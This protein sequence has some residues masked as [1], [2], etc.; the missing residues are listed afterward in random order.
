[1]PAPRLHETIIAE[2]IVELIDQNLIGNWQDLLAVRDVINK[3]IEM[4]RE[5]K[6]IG[7]SLEVRLLVEASDQELSHLLR[8][9]EHALGEAFIVSQVEL[10]SQD[11]MGEWIS[12]HFPSD[13]RSHAFRLSVARAQGAKCERCWK[14]S[15]HVGTFPDHPSL[16]EYCMEVT[17]SVSS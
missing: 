4:K 14:Y 5:A 12:V 6:E 17:G 11:N 8:R 10:D 13:G 16:C 7:S 3:K 9:Y 1:M 15:V 2:K